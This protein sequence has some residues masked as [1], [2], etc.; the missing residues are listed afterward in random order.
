MSVS[1]AFN[2]ILTAIPNL[3]VINDFIITSQHKAFI[4]GIAR[5]DPYSLL[6]VTRAD[7]YIFD[8]VKFI[9]ARQV[10]RNYRRFQAECFSINRVL[11]RCSSALRIQSV[12]RGSLVRKDFHRL[13]RAVRLIQDAVR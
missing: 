4:N 3:I 10:L 7:D 5:F 9:H 6:P 11:R 13:L 1:D 2:Q 12:F 8:F